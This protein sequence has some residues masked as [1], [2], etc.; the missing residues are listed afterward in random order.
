METHHQGHGAAITAYCVSQGIG[1]RVVRTWEGG[2]VEERRLKR[3]KKAKGDKERYV[4][5]PRASAALVGLYLAERDHPESGPVFLGRGGRLSRCQAW[6]IVKD[7]GEM[8]GLG[9]LWTHVLRHS[10]ATGLFG[11]GSDIL[12]VKEYLGHE[13]TRLREAGERL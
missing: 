10:C 8:A 6:R 13:D 4:P 11:T 1:F 12:E 7:A 5:V 2:R 3:R 9:D